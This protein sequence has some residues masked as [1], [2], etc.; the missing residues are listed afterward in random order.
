MIAAGA[1]VDEADHLITKLAVLKNFLGHDAAEVA[2]AGNQDALQPE[3]GF[4]APF[5]QLADEL[6][7][8]ECERD[9]DDQKQRPDDARN[10]IRADGLLL[11]RRVIRVDVKCRDDP[12]DHRDDRADEDEEEVIDARAA[13][14]Q[15]IDALKV[16]GERHEH[17]D[18]RHHRDVLFERRIAAR[19]RDEAARE[20]QEI[21]Q[22]ECGDCRASRPRRRR[23]PRAGV[24]TV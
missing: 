7:R 19:D 1:I 12:E 4:P 23:A 2:R 15:A 8:A 21:R 9:V 14:P 20:S 6:A 10:L 16:V 3:T 13:A 11:W 22:S 18:E 17:G 24:R 5:E